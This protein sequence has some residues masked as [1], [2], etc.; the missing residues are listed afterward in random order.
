[1]PI[2]PGFG[3]LPRFDT[4]RARGVLQLVREKSGWGRAKLPPRTGMGVAVY[5]CHFGYF[6]EVVQA[7][8]TPEHGLKI[9]KVW[10][11]ADC[12]PQTVTPAGAV[13]QVQGAVLDGISQALGLAITLVRGRVAETN[14]HEYKLLRMNQAPPVQVDF[15]ITDHP[16]TG[17]GEPA[18]PP[19][20]P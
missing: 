7:T 20:V 14:F 11:A 10:V 19:A 1:D 6:A 13:N 9:D 5:Y 3:P 16:P 8:V 15:H 18:M 17:L 4:T 2:I 12:G